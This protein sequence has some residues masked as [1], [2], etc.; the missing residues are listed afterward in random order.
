MADGVAIAC[1]EGRL[2]RGQAGRSRD[3]QVVDALPVGRRMLDANQHLAGD[4]CGRL[5]KVGKLEDDSR[6]ADRLICSAS[7]SRLPC[8]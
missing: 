5:G 1:K 7:V 3:L 6:I 2:V 8:Q 4:R